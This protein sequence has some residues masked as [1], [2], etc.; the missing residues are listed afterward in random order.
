MDGTLERSEK[1]HYY[2]DQ[3]W[4]RSLLG[5]RKSRF[6]RVTRNRLLQCLLIL[7][8]QRKFCLKLSVARTLHHLPHW[9]PR[10]VDPE[11]KKCDLSR[12]QVFTRLH[13]FSFL[14]PRFVYSLAGCRIVVRISKYFQKNSKTKL[15]STLRGQRKGKPLRSSGS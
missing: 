7:L 4:V 9:G 14:C 11:R 6:V 12:N 15:N 3:F 10:Q 13:L 5:N 8:G 2:M 1:G